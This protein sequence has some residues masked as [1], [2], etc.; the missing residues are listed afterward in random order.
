MCVLALKL[1]NFDNNLFLGNKTADNKDAIKE[2]P[3][4]LE[5]G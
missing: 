2:T 5:Q 1:K 4:V 3:L